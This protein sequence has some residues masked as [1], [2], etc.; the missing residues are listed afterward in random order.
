MIGLLKLLAQGAD[1]ILIGAV[2]GGKGFAGALEQSRGAAVVHGVAQLQADARDQLGLPLLRERDF[3]LLA[4]GGERLVHSGADALHILVRERLGAADMQRELPLG[5]D[6]AQIARRDAQALGE[7]F[8][9]LLRHTRASGGVF[10]LCDLLC[11]GR[12]DLLGGLGVHLQT[13]LVHETAQ[14]L[15]RLLRDARG[16]LLIAL[17]GGAANALGALLC[18]GE[19]VP[20]LHGGAFVFALDAVQKRFCVFMGCC[21]LPQISA[22]LVPVGADAVQN[23]LAA[24]KIQPD[25]Q[26]HKVNEP[27]ENVP[28][29]HVRSSLLSFPAKPRYLTED[30][31]CQQ[32]GQLPALLFQRLLIQRTL[33]GKLRLPGLELFGGVN[34]GGAQGFG[35]AL[36][37][38]LLR[39]GEDAAC[40]NA[41]LGL[42]GGELFA[43]LLYGLARLLFGVQTCV[44]LR[45]PRVHKAAHRVKQ[46]ALEHEIEK[47]EVDD[48]PYELG[49][50]D[51]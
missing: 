31:L 28:S 21:G 6:A 42:L 44:D 8:D 2:K 51:A 27:I 4:H 3:R 7:L 18:G 39:F 11:R 49:K 40:L 10:G 1:Q 47:K 16:V 37:R 41:R 34:A 35:M 24:D 9:E 36:L 23:D 32:R 50:V 5:A 46:K 14:I 19:N 29:T 22:H 20:T 25:R 12:G 17:G 48:R 33:P 43:V 45:L 38:V 15:M 26:D 13:L 30:A